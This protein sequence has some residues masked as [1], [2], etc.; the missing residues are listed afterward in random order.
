MRGAEGIPN[1]GEVRGRKGGREGGMGRAKGNPN[2]SGEKGQ[3][4]GTYQK[5][6]N[7]GRGE[8]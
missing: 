3:N 1:A 5:T 2:P 6:L 4:G 7:M 8:S